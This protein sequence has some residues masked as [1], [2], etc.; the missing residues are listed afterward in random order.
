VQQPGCCAQQILTRTRAGSTRLTSPQ[1]HAPPRAVCA[2]VRTARRLTVATHGPSGERSVHDN[3]KELL[4]PPMQNQFTLKKWP[5]AE[6][7]LKS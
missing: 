5:K 2:S 6:L 4:T 1:R 3:P 7:T